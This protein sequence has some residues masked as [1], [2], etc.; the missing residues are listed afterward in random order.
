MIIILNKIVSCISP[1]HQCLLRLALV[2]GQQ[3]QRAE[4]LQRALVVPLYLVEG[5]G[6]V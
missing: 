4:Y 6:V 2:H 3:V 5:L 1:V